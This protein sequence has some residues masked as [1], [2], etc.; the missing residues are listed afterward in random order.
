MAVKP[1]FVKHA[2]LRELRAHIRVN[3]DRYRVGEFGELLDPA[4]LN[5]SYFELSEGNIDLNMFKALSA[6]EKNDYKE[7]E[8]AEVVFNALTEL[9]PY[10]AKDERLW[11]YLCHTVGLAHIR[12][13]HRKIF[14]AD[15]EKAVKEIEKVFFVVGGLRGFE[16]TNALARLWSY[17]NIASK[18]LGVPLKQTLEVFLHQTD[19]RAQIVERPSTF[20]NPAVFSALM[21]FMTIQY[22]DIKSRELFFNRKEGVMPFYRKLFARLNELGGVTLLG[23]MNPSALDKIMNLAAKDIGS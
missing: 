15:P 6:P 17:G 9:S 3:L 16:R 20:V 21:R 4:N 19:V 10:H 13:R 5:Q 11:V 1:R 22:K 23:A 2:T 14:D 12:K 8:N 7:A 18:N